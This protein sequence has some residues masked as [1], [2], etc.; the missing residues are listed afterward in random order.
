[1]ITLGDGKRTSF[2]SSG[3]IQGRR[4]RDIAPLL[5]AKTKKKKQ[6]VAEALQNYTWIRDLDY[7]TGFTTA[8]LPQFITLWHLVIVVELQHEQED[9]ITWTQTAHGE[10]TTASVY[11]VQS[12]GCVGNPHIAIIWKTWAPPKC[13]FF[14]R[15]IVQNRVWVFDR[16]ARRE[17]D[18]SPSCPLCRST[19]E[20]AY[21]LLTSCCYTRQV[22]GL[23][24]QWTGLPELKPTEWIHSTTTL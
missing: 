11:K 5:Y 2:W 21:H 14:A 13:K 6:M 15:L 3:W 18:H 4:P 20:T 12:K 22:W 9:Q 7:R 8:H 10:Y 24:A 1:M 16:L 19:M 17:W 23:A